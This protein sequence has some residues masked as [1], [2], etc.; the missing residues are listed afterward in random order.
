MYLDAEQVTIS[1]PWGAL[2]EALDDIFTRTVHSPVRH[3]H[4]LHVPGDPDATLLLMPAWIEGQYLGVKQVNVF[5]GNSGRGQPGLSGH[6]LLS[7]ARTG[8]HLAQFEANELTARRTAAASALAARYLARED[9]RELLMVGAGRMGR[10]LIPAH[11]A[12][13]PIERVRIW[14]IHETGAQALAAE[15]RDEGLDA[16]AVPADGLAEAAGRADIISCA[17]LSP[18]PLIHGEWLTPGTHLDLVGSFTPFMREADDEVMRRGAVFV[19]TRE[20]ALSETGDL[21]DP[22]ASGVIGETDILA[23]FPDLCGGKHPGR[24]A[25]ADPDR[26]ITVFKSVGASVEDLAAA[27]LAYERCR[28]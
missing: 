9:S 21:I 15:L 4:H 5:P 3:H 10:R 8:H 20:G 16:Q 28:D 22:I 1:L 14:D 11:R 13:R 12:V 2:V 18:E 24:A 17:T 25:L 27:I 7:C 26:A 19:D 6:Y 23:D